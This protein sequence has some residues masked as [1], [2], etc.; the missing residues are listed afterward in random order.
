M[1]EDDSKQ[2][3]SEESVLS[4]SAEELVE[5]AID[6]AFSALAEEGMLDA[7]VISLSGEEVKEH[8][9]EIEDAA[10]AVENGR[11]YGRSLSN[12]A[13]VCALVYLGEVELEEGEADAIVVEISERGEESGWIVVQPIGVFEDEEGKTLELVGDPFVVS[14]SEN[15]LA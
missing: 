5:A 14:K 11:A 10:D 15:L 2:A 9:I 3:G 1:S 4:E 7:F 6:G 12:D 13:Q 8:P